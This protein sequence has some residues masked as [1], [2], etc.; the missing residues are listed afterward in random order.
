MLF[1]GL[2]GRGNRMNLVRTQ[3]GLTLFELMVAMVLLVMVSVMLY[4]VLNVGINFAKKGEGRIQ[5]IA[6]ERALLELLHRQVHG[7]WYDRRQK[8]LFIEGD[9]NLLKLVTTSPLFEPD[10]GLIL[11]IYVYDPDDQVLYYSEKIDFYNVD[12][13]ED[14]QPSREEMTIIMTEVPDFSMIYEENKGALAVTFQGAEYE[15]VARCW[16]GEEEL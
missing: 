10:A 5:Y 2:A 16:Q 3:R 1:D 9:E 8:K 4:S 13:Q 11:A 12:Y 15:F 7:A 6:K 14:Y